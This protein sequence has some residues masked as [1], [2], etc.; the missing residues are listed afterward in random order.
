MSQKDPLEVEK[1]TTPVPLILESNTW[2]KVICS[3]RKLY[4]GEFRSFYTENLY[5]DYMH[6]QCTAYKPDI[7]DSKQCLLV[8]R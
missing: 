6:T 2:D 3:W 8:W 4:C 7:E 1:V 5:I